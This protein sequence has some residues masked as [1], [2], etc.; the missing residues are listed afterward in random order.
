[1]AHWGAR[2]P[3]ALAAALAALNAAAMLLF[4]PE[5]LAPANRRAFRL[6]DAHLIG[7]FRPLF[8]ADPDRFERFSWRQDGLLLDLSKTALTGPVLE[9][10]L[11]GVPA[12]TLYVQQFIDSDDRVTDAVKAAMERGGIHL[13][14]APRAELDQMTNGLNHQGM[15]LQVPAYA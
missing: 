2:A 9:A 5:T 6:R 1:M 7:A 13:M 12:T 8:A 15:V 14:E 4:L 10:L 11:G 3:F